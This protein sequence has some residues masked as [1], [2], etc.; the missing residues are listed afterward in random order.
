MRKIFIIPIF[1]LL[2]VIAVYGFPFVSSMLGVSTYAAKKIVDAI[3]I[4]A[5][6]WTIVGLIA[7]GGGVAAI[8]MGFLRYMTKRL[9]RKA[10]I[11]W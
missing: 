9:G 2:F 3:F 5:G 8:G 1:A 10:T 7:A 11:A 4:G 6:F